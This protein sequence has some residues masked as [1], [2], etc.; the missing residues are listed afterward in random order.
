MVCLGSIHCTL[1]TLCD[2]HKLRDA[3]F[4]S[5]CWPLSSYTYIISFLKSQLACKSYYH[6]RLIYSYSCNHTN[7]NELAEHLQGMKQMLGL[8]MPNRLLEIALRC[9]GLSSI[10]LNYP[11]NKQKLQNFCW[12]VAWKTDEEVGEIICSYN[13]HFIT[14]LHVSCIF[15]LQIK[16]ANLLE[17]PRTKYFCTKSKWIGITTLIWPALYLCMAQ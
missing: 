17:G 13:A 7:T 10:T 2:Y 11:G 12:A 9:M 3:S 8:K 15:A 4:I 16:Y 5:S 6:V 14:W 1:Q